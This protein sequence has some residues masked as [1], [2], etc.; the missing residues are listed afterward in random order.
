MCLQC[1][2]RVGRRLVVLHSMGISVTSLN[3]LVTVDKHFF[4]HLKKQ[5]YELFLVSKEGTI[6]NGTFIAKKT[7]NPVDC[8]QQRISLTMTLVIE[9][10][11]VSDKNGDT[12]ESI[13]HHIFCFF[14]EV[15][16]IIE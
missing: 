3:K 12:P 14:N 4:I 2:S 5:N 16:N 7:K 11:I 13:F 6:F 1:K 8:F 10:V 15:N 9:V